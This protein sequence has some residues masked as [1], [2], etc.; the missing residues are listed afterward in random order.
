LIARNAIGRLRRRWTLDRS[1]SSALTRTN[2][3]R[4]YDA[5][6]GSRALLDEYLDPSRLAFY[7]EVAAACAELRPASTVDLGC[8]SG[9]LLR[10]LLHRL[11][12]TRA[13]GV[14]HAPSGI[15]VAR[16]LVPEARFMVGDLYRISPPERFELV[17]CTE[18]LE[19][20]AR[21]REGLERIVEWCAEGGRVAI[22]VPDGA[23]DA[24]EGH[25]NFWSEDDLRAFLA[26]CGLESITRI[27]EGRT[28]LAVLAP[29]S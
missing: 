21:P 29:R 2:S 8:G 18:V 16:E 19:H 4:A 11:P 23:W 1:S 22:T 15:D 10:A 20:L 25:V 12:E 24:F 27:D 13:L 9:H 14:D 3:R 26:P 28:L 5:L 6:Y 17:L 7:D